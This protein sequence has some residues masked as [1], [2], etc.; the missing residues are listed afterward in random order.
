[1]PVRPILRFPDSRLRQK[2]EPVTLFDAA[3]RDL[4]ASMK[5]TMYLAEGAGLAATQIGEPLQLFI[6]D[7]AVAGRADEDSPLVVANPELVWISE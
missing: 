7:P 3:L 1:M 4:V 6:I 2:C 5:D